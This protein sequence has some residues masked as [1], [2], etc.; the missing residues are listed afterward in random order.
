[1]TGF[2]KGDWVRR[3]KQS[4]APENFGE[5]GKIYKVLDIDSI[6]NPIVVS[7]ATAA[8]ASAFEPWQPKIGERVRCIVGTL[9]L[10]EGEIYTVVSGRYAPVGGENG[11][12]VD[13]G[14]AGAME[15]NVDYFE[16][17]LDAPVVVP[18]QP[19][20]IE[21]GKCYTTRDGR[22]VGPMVASYRI[23]Q[24][25]CSQKGGAFYQEN[26]VAPYLPDSHTLI[27]EWQPTPAPTPTA[28]T[29]ATVDAI[30]EEYGP[31]VSSNDTA[32]LTVTLDAEDVH[33]ELDSII[34]KLKKI[35]KLKREL[36]LAA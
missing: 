21:A 23:G 19:L 24:F 14:K 12:F 25:K 30:N 13:A 27:A 29:S 2:K 7:G 1:M 17:I 33:E 20:K 11:F 28:N 5:V 16:P 6:G 22:K 36:G 31:V 34:G 18:A 3:V 35:R 4:H 10:D 15:Y 8:T 32:T 9:I 26:G